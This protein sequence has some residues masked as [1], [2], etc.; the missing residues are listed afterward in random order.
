MTSL[1]DIAVDGRMKKANRV[2]IKKPRADGTKKK[3]QSTLNLKSNIDFNKTETCTE[4]GMTYY[5][6][7]NKDKEYHQEYH[8]TYM[9]GLSWNYTV[10]EPLMLVQIPSKQGNKLVKLTIITV[11]KKLESQVRRAEEVIKMVNTELNASVGSD[12]WKYDSAETVKSQAF[13]AII[14]SKVVGICTTEKLDDPQASRWMLHR[15]QTIIPNQLNRSAKLGISRIWV[16]PRWRRHGISLKLLD[17]TLSNSIYGVRLNKSNISFSQP[18]TRGG[19]LAKNFNGVLHK[20][21]ECLLPV[22]LE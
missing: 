1:K 16:A 19:L 3:V 14:D 2:G 12:A 21:G 18:S 5:K 8:K 9:V 6:Y 4:C 7:V 20:S 17:A 11:N 10:A 13:L 22:Y 15:N